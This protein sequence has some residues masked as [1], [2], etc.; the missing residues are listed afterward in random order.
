M[1]A[2]Q[3]KHLPERR[4]VYYGLGLFVCLPDVGQRSGAFKVGLGFRFIAGGLPSVGIR[5]DAIEADF[6]TP[7]RD[8]EAET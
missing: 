1:T 4:A 2:V 8:T 6:V 5:G 3:S 7:G